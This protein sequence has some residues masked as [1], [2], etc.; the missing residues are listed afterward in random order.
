[1]D[2]VE[3]LCGLLVSPAKMSRLEDDADGTPRFHLSFHVRNDEA[4]PGWIQV[5]DHYDLRHPFR[6]SGVTRVPPFSAVH[7][8]LVLKEP[9]RALWLHPYFSRNAGTVLIPITETAPHTGHDGILVGSEPSTWRPKVDGIV[10]DDLSPGLSVIDERRWFGL[11][12][13][14]SAHTVSDGIVGLPSNR[15]SPGQTGWSRDWAPTSWGKYRATM[16]HAPG[17][18]GQRMALFSTEI[19]RD[20]RWRLDYHMPNT[21]FVM[22]PGKSVGSLEITVSANGMAEPKTLVFDASAAESG[23]SAVGTFDWRA[24]KARVALSDRTDGTHVIADAVRW[25]ETD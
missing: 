2:H 12:W 7:V 6:L 8:G 14:G 22:A 21:Q 24:G 19:G 10:V 15:E 17:G 13:P 1:M 11:A 18:T 20:G 4:S 3:R 16:V 25:V 9:P 5:K 23:W